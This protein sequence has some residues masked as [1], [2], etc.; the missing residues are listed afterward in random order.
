MK[1]KM[2]DVHPPS[3]EIQSKTNREWREREREREKLLGKVDEL[4]KREASAQT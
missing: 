4:G 1:M 2:A 3:T